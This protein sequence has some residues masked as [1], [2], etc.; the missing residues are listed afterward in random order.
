M[1][2]TVGALRLLRRSP[3]QIE[4]MIDNRQF[5]RGVKPEANL[6]CLQQ[7]RPMIP[8]SPFRRLSKDFRPGYSIVRTGSRETSPHKIRHSFVQL[9]QH[10]VAL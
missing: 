1:I 3:E 10:R 6:H 2:H 5:V 4:C 7:E 8:S 9:V